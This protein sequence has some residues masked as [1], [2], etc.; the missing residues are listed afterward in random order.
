VG[1]A[2]GPLVAD[3]VAPNDGGSFPTV[4][5]TTPEEPALATP[6]GTPPIV[7]GSTPTVLDTIG[8]VTACEPPFVPAVD[9]DAGCF[10]GIRL[11]MSLTTGTCIT[12]RTAR[13]RCAGACVTLLCV[14]VRCF[15]VLKTSGAA[16][17]CDAA[18]LAVA[19]G[20]EMAG[21]RSGTTV[22]ACR[23]RTRAGDLIARVPTSGAA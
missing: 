11:R 17:E 4:L 14:T 16:D 20:I 8:G 3:E 12:L 13:W 7:A 5:S 23:E 18:G 21:K 15:C 9:G 6:T 22:S 2:V 10:G 1:A 19:R